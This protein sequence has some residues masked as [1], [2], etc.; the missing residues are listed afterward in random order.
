MDRFFCL[1][2][3]SLRLLFPDCDLA[4]GGEACLRRER[5]RSD[6]QNVGKHERVARIHLI[7]ARLRAVGK[8]RGG[9]TQAIS[10]SEK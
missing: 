1:L 4:S 3:A 10:Q 7:S 9:Q 6:I 8:C 2:Q 5:E